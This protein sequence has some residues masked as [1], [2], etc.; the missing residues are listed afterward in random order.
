[1]TAATRRRQSVR[2]QLVWWNILALALLLGALGVV[3][4]TLVRSTITN[5]IDRELSGR[6]RG[7][8]DLMERRRDDRGGPSD[9]R[10]RGGRD[11][12]RPRPFD[13]AGHWLDPRHPAEPLLDPAAFVLAAGGKA[14]Y[15]TAAVDGEPRPASCPTPSL[16]RGRS[17][18]ASRPR[19]HWRTSTAPCAAWT[20]PCSCCCPSPS[21]AR[22]WPAPFSLTASCSECGG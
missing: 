16:S 18:A 5:S 17:R 10:P 2:T 22:V 3:V 7:M 20:V 6:T 9:L 8:M 15:S 14:T 13:L 4:R 1:M 11:P 19:T 12:Y 21:S